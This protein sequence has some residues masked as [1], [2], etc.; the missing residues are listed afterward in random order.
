MT[1][2]TPKT[3]STVPSAPDT[4]KSDGETKPAQTDTVMEHLYSRIDDLERRVD[5]YQGRLADERERR[6]SMEQA[7]RNYFNRNTIDLTMDEI[8]EA[9]RS[10]LI[11]DRRASTTPKGVQDGGS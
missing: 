5:S 1:E 6:V 10:I 9:A 11:D 8:D 4:T 2:Q 3:L 7:L